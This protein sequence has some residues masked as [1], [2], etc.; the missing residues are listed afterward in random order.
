MQIAS[1]RLLSILM[2]HICIFVCVFVFLSWGRVAYSQ[3]S[4]AASANG[5]VVARVYPG[6]LKETSASASIFEWNENARSLEFRGDLSLP[7]RRIPNHILLSNDGKY[8]VT[9]GDISG[10]DDL[11]NAVVVVDL[12]TKEPHAFSLK[13]FVPEEDIPS[14]SNGYESSQ[15]EHFRHFIDWVNDVHLDES[16]HIAY[17]TGHATDE[18][19]ERRLYAIDLTKPTVMRVEPPFWKREW[20]KQSLMHLQQAKQAG[21]YLTQ[22]QNLLRVLMATTLSPPPIQYKWIGGERVVRLE[23]G[24]DEVP[25]SFVF[26][27]F[28]P[29]TKSFEA[30]YDIKLENPKAPS[31][32]KLS[33]DLNF[34]VTLDDCDAIGLNERAV[35][36][37]DLKEG[38]RKKF[39]L[40]Q[41]LPKDELDALKVTKN[42][43]PWRDSIGRS[44]FMSEAQFVEPKAPKKDS[45]RC[46]LIEIDPEKM[47]VRY[48]G[49]KST[50]Q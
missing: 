28:D 18:L 13:E 19:S 3:F 8:L 9:I 17:V 6:D 38:N 24:H 33:S 46:P 32:F 42:V 43:R 10:G 48:V 31:E 12:E 20:D 40:E 37:Y 34:L 41:F 5:Q 2:R 30:K 50:N 49:R 23:P 44:I 7:N 21:S 29:D 4:S 25:A 27:S 16:E 39:S 15:M 1:F 26:A 47:S 11:D 14:E 35:V 22:D 36:I 45:I